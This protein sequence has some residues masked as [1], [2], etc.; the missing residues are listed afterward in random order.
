MSLIAQA[1]ISLLSLCPALGAHRPV[2]EITTPPGGSWG[3]YRPNVVCVDPRT[4]RR[5]VR[6]VVTHEVIHACLY[7]EG[8][9]WRN[10]R[11]VARL[12]KEHLDG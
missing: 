6:K 10:E 9:D 5:L 8:G 4:P 2:L 7:W 1:F 12:T 3:A 11:L